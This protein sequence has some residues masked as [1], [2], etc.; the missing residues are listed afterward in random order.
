V[1]LP[2]GVFPS[3]MRSISRH[4]RLDRGLVQP[5]EAALLLRNA[6]SRGLRTSPHARRSRGMITTTNLSAGPGEAQVCSCGT[7]VASAFG[8]N[9]PPNR[10]HRGND[11]W[12]SS[13]GFP[14]QVSPR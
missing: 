9:A 12:C 3:S 6:R 4:V 7:G 11:C 14:A 13:P 8:R 10:Q 5:V 2:E 1:G